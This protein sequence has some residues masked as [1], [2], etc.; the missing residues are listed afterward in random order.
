MLIRANYEGLLR[1]YAIIAA[2]NMPL[3]SSLSPFFPLSVS[4]VVTLA[5]FPCFSFVFSLLGGGGV[6]EFGIYAVKFTLS[7]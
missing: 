4:V 5:I 2:S 3:R 7:Q 6:S 1:S